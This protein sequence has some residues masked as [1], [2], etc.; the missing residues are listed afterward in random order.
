MSDVF[1]SYARRDVA[2][3]QIIRQ[4]L[5]DLGLKVFFDLEGLDSGDV[6]P[7]V[8]DKAVKSAKCVVGVWSA[9]SLTR[10][11]VKT[12]CDIGRARGVLVPVQVERI[13]DLDRPAAFWNLHYDDLSQFD[14]DPSHSDWLS[15]VRSVSRTLGRPDLIALARARAGEAKRVA[16]IDRAPVSWSGGANQ[17][18][19]R[20]AN[21]AVALVMAAVGAGIAALWI[22]GANSSRPSAAE[23]ASIQELAESDP[24]RTLVPE[25]PADP[26][27]EAWLRAL[28]DGGRAA[29]NAYLILFPSGKYAADAEEAIGALD[30]RVTEQ[31]A[32]SQ[33]E[34]ASLSEDQ[35][36][37]EAII[38]GSEKAFSEFIAA[39]P[40]SPRKTEAV[41]RRDVAAQADRDRIA[42]TTQQVLLQEVPANSPLRSA[43]AASSPQAAAA[44]P[45]ANWSSSTNPGTVSGKSTLLQVASAGAGSGECRTVR[46]LII[47]EGK[48]ATRDV[49]FCRSGP[50]EQWTAAE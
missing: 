14:G 28:N 25:V 48:E 9:H 19:F 42:A 27:N 17:R 44:A 3:A 24:A 2:R 41:R 5:E 49:A 18:R 15:F 23:R 40:D 32:R 37:S 7:D 13:N 16:H 1:L 8:L 20:P 36:W 31:R 38:A 12:E 26:D 30:R 43:S 21:V 22:Q 46:Q 33:P 29:M 45:S 11:W 47:V 34:S 10:A 39:F 50:G 35:A 6:F 4:G